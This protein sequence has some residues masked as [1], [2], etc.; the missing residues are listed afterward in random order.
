M[1][2]VTSAR[3]NPGTLREYECV[4]I[5]RPD[6]LQEGI[7]GLNN[8]IKELIEHDGGRMLLVENWGKRRL[9]YEIRKQL[10][11]IY[12]YYQFLGH[13]PLIGEM[14]RNFQLLESVIR[15][16]T[17]R[18]DENVDPTARPSELSE[19]DFLAASATRRD[20]ASLVF[21]VG[22]EFGLMGTVLS[23]SFDSLRERC[24]TRRIGTILH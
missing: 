21:G 5:L 16:F 9:A 4:L 1:P 17:T 20:S 23:A 10:K 7:L 11:G 3:D 24:T 8:K 13:S 19:E 12:M 14:E 2:E 22:F 6:T 15:Y 18:I